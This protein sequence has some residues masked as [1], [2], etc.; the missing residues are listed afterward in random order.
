MN[1]QWTLAIECAIET[2][3]TIAK[4]VEFVVSIALFI[5]C[6]LQ[7]YKLYLKPLY[8]YSVQYIAYCIS[9]YKYTFSYILFCYII[10]LRDVN[11][12]GARGGHYSQ[13]FEILALIHLPH[14]I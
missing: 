5:G 3:H 1:L 14:P 9:A 6:P 4:Y 2:T 8:L 10:Y 11:N 7:F 12:A 13:S